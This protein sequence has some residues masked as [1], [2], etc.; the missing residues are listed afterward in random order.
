M[1]Q[2]IPKRVYTTK[3]SAMPRMTV[4]P[5]FSAEK[6]ECGAIS[7]TFQMSNSKNMETNHNISKKPAIFKNMETDDMILIGLL[8]LLL[9]EEGDNQ[10]LLAVVAFLLFS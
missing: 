7:D 9:S 6:K 1:Y 4:S 10:L 5:S 2:S 3:E 8:L